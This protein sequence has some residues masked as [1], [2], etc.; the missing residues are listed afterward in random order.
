MHRYLERRAVW[1]AG[2]S[3]SRRPAKKPKVTYP[4]IQGGPVTFLITLDVNKLTWPTAITTGERQELN[5]FG[6]TQHDRGSTANKAKV[7][8]CIAKGFIGYARTSSAT[9]VRRD[10]H[11]I[12]KRLVASRSDGAE[13][14]TKVLSVMH[15]DVERLLSE[16]IVTLP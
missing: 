12:E 13:A 2:T 11:A 7:L 9:V 3:S 14:R 4:E 8:S 16:W 1:K 15:E 10:R 6:F 5:K